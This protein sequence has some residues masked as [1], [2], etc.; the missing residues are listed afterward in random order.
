M[1][2][3][4]RAEDGANLPQDRVTPDEPP[5]TNV[6]VDYFGPFE[7]KL[8]RSHV[9]RYGVIFTCL[10][11]RAVHL[12][13]A[14]SLDTNSYINVLRRFIARL[15]QV[16]MIRSDNGTNF[17]GAERELRA[18]LNEWNL[19]QIDHAMTQRNIDWKFN[20]PSGSHFG[21]VWE[22]LI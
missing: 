7:V 19:G 4:R 12:E 18:A 21:G 11:T 5:F 1:C 6:G 17:V 22:R 10:S 15:G 14:S 9:K 16:K 8:R 3:F 2:T 20:P 13:V